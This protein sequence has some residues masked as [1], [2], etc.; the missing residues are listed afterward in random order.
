MG[1]PFHSQSGGL[2]VVCAEP[3]GDLLAGG[4]VRALR[5]RRPNLPIFGMGGER[6]RDA[7]METLL[8]VSLL[9]VM[10]FSEVL[11]AIPRALR[12]LSQLTRAATERQPTAALLVDAP[13]FNLRLAPRLAALGVPVVGYVSPTVWAWRSGR[14]RQIARNFAALCCV[15]PFEEQFYARHGFENARYVGHPL[16]EGNPASRESARAALGIAKSAPLLALL[17]GSRRQEVARL[18]PI[19]AATA[20]RLCA[21]SPALQLVVPIAPGLSSGWVEAQFARGGLRPRTVRMPAS[22]VVAAA[23]AAIVASGTATLETALAGTPQVVVYRMSW[24]SWLVARLLVRT[25]FVALPNL[26]AEKAIV[27]E[28][29]QSGCTPERI[30]AAVRPLLDRASVP[31]EAQRVACARLRTSLGS[32]GAADRVATQLLSAMREAA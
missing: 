10:G 30:A 24:I 8:D 17:P 15:L 26:L 5:L 21:D 11:G 29:L 19:L 4:V 1:G 23:D 31:R 7:G 25:R 32:P 6:C 12:A 2:L 18:A 27:P 3:S 28:L 22:D 20:A 14:I 9:S 13:D 16:L